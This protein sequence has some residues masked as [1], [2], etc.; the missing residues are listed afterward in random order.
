M[1]CARIGLFFLIPLVLCLGMNGCGSA[2]SLT[3][4]TPAVK[5]QWD[6]V[7][8]GIR[9]DGTFSM[10]TALQ[11]FSVA[12]APLPGVPL[13]AGAPVHLV[14]GTMAI[15]MVMT[16]WKDLSPQQQQAINKILPL[17]PPASASA[18]SNHT[19]IG[20]SQRAGSPTPTTTQSLQARAEQAWTQI[21]THLQRN[22]LLIQVFLLDRL[23]D[24]ADTYVF[25]DTGNRTGAPSRCDILVNSIEISDITPI[26]LQILMTHE[27]FHCFEFSVNPLQITYSPFAWITEGLATWAG[28]TITGFSY[29]T[30]LLGYFYPEYILHPQKPLFERDYD[31]VGFYDHMTQQ[32]IDVWSKIDAMLLAPSSTAALA[33][34]VPAGV[35]AAF[36]Y[37]WGASYFRHPAYGSDWDMQGVGV[38]PD[39]APIGRAHVGSGGTA[40]GVTIKAGPLSS[41]LYQ[42]NVDS[43]VE[44]LHVVPAGYVRLHDSGTVDSGDQGPATEYSLAGHP[45]TCPSD[46]PDAG[47]KLPTL[48]GPLSLAVTGGEATGS[49]V[50][51][52]GEKLQD[53]C[54]KPCPLPKL[55]S[56]VS[57]SPD[58]LHDGCEPSASDIYQKAIAAAS[59]LQDASF[60]YVTGIPNTST[61]TA[62][63]VLTRSPLR[64][65]LMNMIVTTHIGNTP[66]G[67]IIYDDAS[68]LIYFHSGNGWT[69]IPLGNSATPPIFS[70]ALLLP[71]STWKMNSGVSIESVNGRPTYHLSGDSDGDHIDLWIRTDDY[72]VAKRIDHSSS[73]SYAFTFT[74]WNSGATITLP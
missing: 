68:G 51:I 39:M 28:Y 61:T 35:K 2:S 55:A 8:S 40:A 36:F 57:I 5:T 50:A 12:I 46:T 21:A 14:S 45:N 49:Q 65:E 41:S 23:N 26:D 11:A 43:D 38:T 29:S 6:A 20:L 42:V 44:V 34:A 72:N 10:E 31:A 15:D 3:T 64:L 30:Y 4:T 37:S 27:V 69:T 32:G 25:D 1:K 18:N 71:P 74:A 63:G 24:T 59:K 60:Q 56:A 22:K 13:P 17:T 53:V 19:A 73:A 66:A 7:L 48:T 58:L 47:E 16:Y 33:I 67:P 70:A 9:P 52:I 62:D 54:K